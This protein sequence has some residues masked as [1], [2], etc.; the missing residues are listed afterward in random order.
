MNNLVNQIG[1]KC[2]PLGTL[3]ENFKATEQT[4]VFFIQM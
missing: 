1:I 4:A 3:L 2:Y